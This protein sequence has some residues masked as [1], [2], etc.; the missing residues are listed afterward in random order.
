MNETNGRLYNVKRI[1]AIAV[2]IMLANIISQ[3]Q[4]L[5]D[6]IFIGR[7]SID[8]MSAVSNASTPLWT[9]MSTIFSLTTGA[10]ILASQAYGAKDTE[11][12]KSILAS[13]MK[14]NNVLGVALF[15]FWL[16]CPEYV[17]HSMG[18]DESIIGMSLDYARFFSPIFIFSKILCSISSI[19][20][21]SKEQSKSL[22]ICSLLYI[23]F[24]L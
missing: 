5:I 8:S 15:L 10:T 6:R 17:F 2:P 20:T 14:Y 21:S 16:L 9:T 4:M 3:V 23:S 7:L 13:V 22:F 11:R 19:C 24:C 1:L 12:A 18:V